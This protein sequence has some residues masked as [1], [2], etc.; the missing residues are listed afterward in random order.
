MDGAHGTVSVVV[1]LDLELEL[2]LSSSS[3]PSA[4][5]V[6]VTGQGTT[7]TTVVIGTDGAGISEHPQWSKV[8][9]VVRQVGVGEGHVC[10]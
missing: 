4:A 7:S 1:E 3:S 2:A 6:A 10:C 5:A 8:M 9:V